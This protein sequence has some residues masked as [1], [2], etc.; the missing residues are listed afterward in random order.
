MFTRSDPR[1]GEFPGGNHIWL[2]LTSGVENM[3]NLFN[4]KHTVI[5]IT[6]FTKSICDRNGRC[7][8]ALIAVVLSCLY[9]CLLAVANADDSSATTTYPDATRPELIKYP[10]MAAIKI[11]RHRHRT[12]SVYCSGVLI[13]PQW[14]LT[15]ASCVE[16]KYPRDIEVLLGI[17]NLNDPRVERFGVTRSIGHPG[18]TNDPSTADVKVALLQLARPATA[19][20]LPFVDT[21]CQVT[22]RTLARLIGWGN[23]SAWPDQAGLLGDGLLPLLPDRHSDFQPRLYFCG[24]R[25]DRHRQLPCGQDEG[26]PVIIN[27]EV[28]GEPR[29]AGLMHEQCNGIPRQ[30]TFVRLTAVVD[31]IQRQIDGIASA[32]ETSNL[33]TNNVVMYD[34]CLKYTCYFEGSDSNTGGVG[35]KRYHWRID[36]AFASRRPRFKHVFAERGTYTFSLKTVL[37]DGRVKE[38]TRTVKIPV[39]SPRQK[40]MDPN[41]TENLAFTTLKF[42]G[43]VAYASYEGSSSTFVE[44]YRRPNGEY[45]PQHLTMTPFD[46]SARF[47]FM[48]QRYH[49]GKNR[50]VTFAHGRPNPF[51][52]HELLITKPIKKAG[53]YRF[54]LK[55]IQG[56]G[57][58][59]LGIF[60]LE[61]NG[62]PSVLKYSPEL[63]QHCL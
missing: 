34:Y 18:F 47:S 21:N 42:A 57:F 12:M 5:V 35:I 23:G 52:R 61:V 32:E 25:E 29:L 39:N 40:D 26:G 44:P 36:G 58:A 31:W 22:S 3:L 16:S 10:W 17:S 60:G 49:F 11:R 6:S 51:D 9:P 7:Q 8:F 1:T 30:I 13:A 48:M 37:N 15:L 38:C 56:S 54:R 45:R 24:K 14:V 63:E 55:S 41:D 33:F 27:D 19:A 53:L 28:T 50:W 20:T 59:F 43:D 46:G 4:V 62:Q 2:S